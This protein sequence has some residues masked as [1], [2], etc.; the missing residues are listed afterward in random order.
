[1]KKIPLTQGQ[2]AIVDDWWY[3]YLMQWKWSA[4]W[5]KSTKSFYAIRNEGKYPNRKTILMHRVVSKTPEKMLCDHIYHNTLDNR[6]SELRNVT[7]SQSTI[8]TKKPV[9]NKT[10]EKGVYKQ[11]DCNGFRVQLRFQG[12]T[13]LNKV[14]STFE[15]AVK[16]RKIYEKIYFQE[17]ANRSNT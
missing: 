1:M 6:E 3:D 16:V 4:R 11:K 5:S 13:V 7:Q 17:Y 9:T 12:K 10:G 14:F 15:E 8:N 2:E